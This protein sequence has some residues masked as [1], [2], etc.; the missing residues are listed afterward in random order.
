[1]IS[2]NSAPNNEFCPDPKIGN[3]INNQETLKGTGRRHIVDGS[4]LR[5]EFKKIIQFPTP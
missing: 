1:M 2:S 3:I 4:D 5:A